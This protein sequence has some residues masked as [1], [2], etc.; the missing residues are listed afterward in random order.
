MSNYTDFFPSGSGGVSSNIKT[1]P[2]EMPISV[3]RLGY[4]GTSQWGTVGFW[5]SYQ[6]NG[7]ST[8]DVFG[9]VRTE[10]VNVVSG[11]GYLHNVITQA[12]GGAGGQNVNSSIYITLDG[13][14]YEIS[15]LLN[16]EGADEFQR[17]VLGYVNT[18][19]RNTFGGTYSSNKQNT[20]INS[21]DILPQGTIEMIQ[22]PILRFE[23]SLKVEVHIG[24]NQSTS[25]AYKTG[26]TYRI[27]S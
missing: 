11:S 1:N 25:Y 23:N 10:L 24:A 20:Y 15:G 19:T 16:T 21:C 2:L 27:D 13:T 26:V 18:T 17:L 12:T 6:G 14:E 8:Q 7:T 5:N 22:A 3:A 4:I 9:S